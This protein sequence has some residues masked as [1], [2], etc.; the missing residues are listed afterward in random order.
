MAET[1]LQS[2]QSRPRVLN[3]KVRSRFFFFFFVCEGCCWMTLIALHL[4]CGCLISCLA[5]AMATTTTGEVAEM[6]ATTTATEG[7]GAVVAGDAAGDVAG[8]D[9]PVA[10]AAAAAAPFPDWEGRYD[11][12]DKFLLRSGPKAVDG[13]RLRPRLAAFLFSC[14]SFCV[15]IG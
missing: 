12:L 5:T 1:S 2:A 6:D 3:K 8:S 11:H 9:E 7:A 14:C 15:W 4:S 10:A 13:R